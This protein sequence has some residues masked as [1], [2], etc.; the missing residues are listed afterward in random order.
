MSLVTY[1]DGRELARRLQRLRKNRYLAYG[2]AIAAVAM[3]TLLR[4]AIDKYLPAGLPFITYFGAVAAATLLGG[5]G[6]GIAAVVLSTIVAWFLFLQPPLQLLLTGSEALA[7]FVF[8]LLSML[9]VAIVTALNG[10]IDR[11]IA[12]EQS[13]EAEIDR[14]R[15]AERDSQRL[16]AIVES[17]DDAIIGKDLDGIITSWNKGAERLYGYTSEEALGQPVLTLVPP[18]RHDEEP[19]ILARL[20]RGERIDH[21]ETVRQRKDG[22]LVDVSLT[23]SPIIDK[24]GTIIGASKI[25][26][27]ISERKRTAEQKDLLI[28]EMSHRVKNAFAVMGGLVAMSVRN[29]VTPEA[30]AR[31]MHARLAALTRAHDLTRPGLIDTRLP[32]GTTS[33]HALVRAIFEPFRDPGAPERLTINGP[34]ITVGERFVTAVALLFHELATNSVKCGCLSAANGSVR[35]ELAT[36]DGEL[37]AKWVEAGG[38]VINGA[39]QHQGFGTVLASRIVTGQFG[40]QLF[41]DWK[42]EGLVVT[43][44]LPLERLTN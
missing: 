1:F 10:A 26:R 36:S 19:A 38:P 17:S 27:D 42:P 23:V 30:M 6:P 24:D 12:L 11:S 41:Y 18:D 16:A 2:L 8:I 3:A 21:Y 31:E 34:D 33:F 35:L 28:K 37:Q 39:P 7:L 20:R 5:F 43:L 9:L 25:A 14:C 32:V 4:L 40:G 29:A 44:S 15:R 22:T 13:L